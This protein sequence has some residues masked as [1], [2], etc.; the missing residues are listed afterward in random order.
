MLDG[1]DGGLLFPSEAKNP[2]QHG[3]EGGGGFRRSNPIDDMTTTSFS[4]LLLSLSL[5]IAVGLLLIVSL[6]ALLFILRH[7]EKTCRV[8]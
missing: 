7:R 2:T 6:R 4:G 1:H 8:N 5:S 3:Q